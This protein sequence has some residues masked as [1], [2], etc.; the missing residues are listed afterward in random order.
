[1]IYNNRRARHL[2]VLNFYKLNFT[3]RCDNIE[4]CEV[5][6][7]SIV[8]NKIFIINLNVLFRLFINID[9]D[10]KIYKQITFA[11]NYVK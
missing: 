3:N 7:T 4:R 10:N 1:M 6:V 8:I 9:Y 2:F 5:F 11:L